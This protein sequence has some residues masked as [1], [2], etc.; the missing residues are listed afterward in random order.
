MPTAFLSL[1]STVMQVVEHI[2]QGNIWG[3]MNTVLAL[4]LGNVHSKPTRTAVSEFSEVHRSLPCP[5]FLIPPE[6]EKS[7]LAFIQTLYDWEV[8]GRPFGKWITAGK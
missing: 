3:N 2:D 8:E 1:N 5:G 7:V 6:D 4:M